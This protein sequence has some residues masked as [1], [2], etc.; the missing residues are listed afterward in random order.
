M[1]HEFIYLLWTL[2]GN[3]MFFLADECMYCLWI[4]VGK[5][6]YTYLLLIWIGHLRLHWP[7]AELGHWVH[8]YLLLIW[9]GEYIC[10]L[11]KEQA[12]WKLLCYASSVADQ[13]W[14]RCGFCSCCL[15]GCQFMVF[16]PLPI[17]FLP[18]HHPP[19]PPLPVSFFLGFVS[20]P[21]SILSPTTDKRSRQFH[22]L[23]RVIVLTR[24]GETVIIVN[25]QRVTGSRFVSCYL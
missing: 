14:T 24:L 5:Y 18:P 12:D 3:C 15:V 17:C 13:S 16:F 1:V 2:A 10:L 20:L 4:L 7:S 9:V 11:L 22:T 6:V 23:T 21:A 8:S 25:K 19:P